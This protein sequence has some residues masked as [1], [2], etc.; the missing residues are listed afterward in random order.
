MRD[1]VRNRRLSTGGRF[2]RDSEKTALGFEGSAS[3]FSEKS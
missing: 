3:L 2:D 1:A